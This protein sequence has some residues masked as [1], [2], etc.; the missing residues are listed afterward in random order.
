MDERLVIIDGYS[1]AN[2]AYFGF[3][4]LSKNG[5]PTNAV[6]GLTMMM[7]SLM[8]EK[9]SHIAVAFDVSAPTFRH[10]QYAQY[11]GTRRKMDDELRTQFP[12]IRRL[13]EILQIPIY[14]QAGFEA[15]DIIGT[16]SVQAANSGMRVDIITGDRDSFQ[17]VNDKV[18]V[19]YTKKGF[20]ELDRVDEEY[21]WDKYQLKPRQIIELKGLMGDSSDNIPG[22]PGFGEKTALKYLYQFPSIAELYEHLDEVSNARH[23]NLMVEY[24]DQA[25]LSRQL[26]EIKLDV[27]LQPDLKDCS[28]HLNYNRSELLDFCKEW[29]FNS[30]VHKLESN[31]ESIVAEQTKPISSKVDVLDET[32][33]KDLLAEIR[34]EGRCYLQFLTATANWSQVT[35][36]A[37]G[38]ASEKRNGYFPLDFSGQIPDC[39][40]ALLADATIV[41]CGYD[42]K[43]QAMIAD[44]LGFELNGDFEDCQIAAYLLNAGVGSLELEELAKTYLNVLIPQTTNERGTKCS[45]F[46]LPAQLLLVTDYSELTGARLETLKQLRPVFERLFAEQ[47]ELKKLFDEIEVPLIKCLLHMEQAGIALNPQVLRDFGKELRARQD[48]LETAIYE[49]AGENFNIASPRQLGIVLFEKLSLRAPKKTK[50]GYSTDAAVLE[51]LIND[52]PIIP[53]IMEY[54]QNVKLQSTYIDSLIALISSRSGRVHTFFNQAVTTTGRL[55]S[56]EPNLQ[57]IP[58]R[59]VEGKRIRNAF[60]AANDELELLAADYSQI[61]LRVM[62]HFSGDEAFMD[63]FLHNEDI[64]RYTAAAVHGVAPEEVTSEIRSAAKAVNFGIIYG[65]SAF[66]LAKNIGIGRKQAEMFIENYFN[67]YPGV[68]AYVEQLIEEA[69]KT[70]ETKTLLGRLRKLP[71]LNSRNFQARAFA[72]RMARNTPIQGTAADIIKIAMVRIQEHLNEN[73]RLGKMLLQVHDELIFEVPKANRDELAALVKREMENAVKLNVPL[74]V[75]FKAGANWGQLQKIQIG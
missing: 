66:G 20:S 73:P 27:P 67:S 59:T 1:L 50:T 62:A 2:R 64:H 36:L 23:H 51:E 7:L 35:C 16:F 49:A 63:A 57:N 15:D 12:L 42:L 24:R 30:I 72:E 33:L 71:D 4:P 11:K 10:E 45:I 74:V 9:P 56:T 22:I 21:I 3:P 34:G 75:D 70:G 32:S 29:G 18:N 5:Q 48:V 8:S 54:R 53:L 68:K 65:I 17:L 13:F 41:K 46:D 37:V 52:H 6:Y 61:E 25:F 14:E 60:I 55:S 28:L 31:E 19:L 38:L 69:R 43:K 44:V 58:V 39:L 47:S 40:S 26:A